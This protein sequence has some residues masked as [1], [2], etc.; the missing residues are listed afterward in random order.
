MPRLDQ[1][2]TLQGLISRASNPNALL[3]RIGDEL[4]LLTE[5]RFNT[6]TTPAGRPWPPLAPST[7]ERKR[8]D[9]ILTETGQMSEQISYAVNDGTLAVG[10]TKPS[11]QDK[12]RAHNFGV[13][14]D[15]KVSAHT[16]TI[17]QAFGKPLDQPQDVQVSAHT[18]SM[19]MPQRQ[20]LSWSREYI[21]TAKRIAINF[22]F[23]SS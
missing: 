22:L 14:R 20:F 15:V 16:R 12:M 8:N 9:S 2:D 17:T 11:E 5:E 3:R 13:D 19:N 23:G 6:E 7:K 4:L 1:R 18:R 21:R 10:G